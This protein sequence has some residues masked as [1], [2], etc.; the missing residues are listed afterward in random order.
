MK[1]ER[2]N[3]SGGQLND[4]VSSADERIF[5]DEGMGFMTDLTMAMSKDALRIT[6][7]KAKTL[8]DQKDTPETK[9]SDSVQSKFKSLLQSTETILAQLT[10]SDDQKK[11]VVSFLTLL[12]L[13]ANFKMKVEQ[14]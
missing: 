11:E 14:I 3:P 2:D 10:L 5:S 12:P 1:N 7:K 13:Y 8:L 9:E 4:L 6:V